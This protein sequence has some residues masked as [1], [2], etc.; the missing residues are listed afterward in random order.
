MSPEIVDETEHMIGD[1]SPRQLSEVQQS[2]ISEKKLYMDEIT[3]LIRKAT[4]QTNQIVEA[5]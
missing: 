5:A 1:R 4:S 2:Q 3:A